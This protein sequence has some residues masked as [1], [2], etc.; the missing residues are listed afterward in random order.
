[1]YELVDLHAIHPE[2]F[3][4]HKS[5]RYLD[6][7][8]CGGVK[9]H[10]IGSRLGSGAVPLP[11]N[12]EWDLLVV[13]GA[14]ARR[15]QTGDQNTRSRKKGVVS[16]GGVTWTWTCISGAYVLLFMTAL[17]LITK[18]LR[19]FHQSTAS[20]SLRPDSTLL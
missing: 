4:L 2:P 9:V 6:S 3:P 7:C 10:E 18:A 14:R 11:V 19:S 1:M 17:A 12:S 8:S 20:E 16:L 13:E 5:A 15:S